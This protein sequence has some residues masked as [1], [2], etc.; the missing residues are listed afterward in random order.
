M[1]TIG[2][3]CGEAFL[4]DARGR[5]KIDTKGADGNTLEAIA[6]GE[7]SA[8]GCVALGAQI[9]YFGRPAG[10]MSELHRSENARH[11]L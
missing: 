1:E 5:R 6:F 7:D 10:Q 4:S 9:G 8:L 3:G 2:R 11:P